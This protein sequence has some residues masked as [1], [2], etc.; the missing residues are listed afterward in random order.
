MR[1]AGAETRRGD[2]PGGRGCARDELL[3]MF[4]RYSKRQSRMQ[5]GS[6]SGTG[7]VSDEDRVEGGGNG[8]L[9]GPGGL[10]EAV[11]CERGGRLARS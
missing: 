7:V 1:R 11:S 10:H 9:E 2:A 5:R 8:A 3:V 4:D 6:G